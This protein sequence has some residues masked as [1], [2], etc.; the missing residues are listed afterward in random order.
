MF[1]KWSC[2][3]GFAPL[4]PIIVLKPVPGWPAGLTCHSS[5]LMHPTLHP[6]H[7]L[8]NQTSKPTFHSRGWS[9]FVSS[10]PTGSWGW[11]RWQRIT[12]PLLEKAPTNHNTSTYLTPSAH[13]TC[14]HTLEHTYTFLLLSVHPL[15]DYIWCYHLKRN[16]FQ[17][18]E[19]CQ[20]Y[21]WFRQIQVL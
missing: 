10:F 19:L 9:H 8:S 7:P 16:S 4:K 21:I 18:K 13:R 12:S 14:T 11:W 3:S 2:L 15:T 5:S 1:P 17:V 6:Q 20:I